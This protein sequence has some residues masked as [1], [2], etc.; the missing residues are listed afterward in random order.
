M[1][2][3]IPVNNYPY[4]N[5]VY[6]NID[7]LV[8]IVAKL[9]ESGKDNGEIK[10][11]ADVSAAYSA[12][13]NNY[14]YT[15]M[16]YQNIDWVID[17]VRK[18]GAEQVKMA[19]QLETLAADVKNIVD[20][21]GDKLDKLTRN[22]VVYAT[23]GSTPAKTI[24]IGYSEKP[25][26]GTIVLRDAMGSV[27]VPAA[28]DDV[29]AVNKE[30]LE[31]AVESKVDKVRKK[32]QIYGTDNNGNDTTFT[33]T[34]AAPQ[35][36]TIPLR[37]TNGCIK[38][39]E[40][41]AGEDAATKNYVDSS[42]SGWTRVVDE[43]VTNDIVLNPET[44]EGYQHYYVGIADLKPCKQLRA[45]LYINTPQEG[46]VFES[47]SPQIQVNGNDSEPAFVPITDIQ[48]LPT[49]DTT[50]LEVEWES[51]GY[52]DIDGIRIVT[53]AG[54]AYDKGIPTPNERAPLG[55]STITYTDTPTNLDSFLANRIH[56]VEAG[57]TTKTYSYQ[58]AIGQ[59]TPP[60]ANNVLMYDWGILT[61]EFTSTS[62]F[63]DR[64]MFYADPEATNDN[65]IV[66]MPTVNEWDS[67]F[68]TWNCQ[69]ASGL[70]VIYYAKGL[71]DGQTSGPNTWQKGQLYT[72]DGAGNEYPI[73][74]KACKV[75]SPVTVKYTTNDYYATNKPGILLSQV[76]AAENGKHIGE[77]VDFGKD[78]SACAFNW[79]GEAAI[80]YKQVIYAE[81]AVIDE[82]I[83][84]TCATYVKENTLTSFDSN[85]VK[86]Q[87][88]TKYCSG[89]FADGIVT[90]IRYK[91]PK[92]TSNG[93]NAQKIYAGSRL[94]LELKY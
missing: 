64:V 92:S 89:I 1:A 78:I 54:K 13:V 86:L 30:Q 44:E 39:G 52:E 69:L 63:A 8:D 67:T 7:W 5:M 29:Q 35:R 94:I 42:I 46:A 81:A 51:N 62:D 16:V 48:G 68:T 82:S 53:Y 26:E 21:E 91:L 28:V 43:V 34:S 40:P 55:H 36:Y 56:E 70:T 4:T 3:N 90:Q 17:S 14:P 93:V 41:I 19:A 84:T 87:D 33:Q 6:R 49:E 88:N 23:D 76:I 57:V 66:T 47:G 38:A 9:V 58:E 61:E 77:L 80:S 74:A 15:N 32:N 73:A 79:S 50:P 22:N 45:K 2:N 65:P 20:K 37:D 83:Q 31:A 10:V 85:A 72:V 12:F 11:D 75:E 27:T 71:T 24:G 18:I 60:S 25:D 59:P